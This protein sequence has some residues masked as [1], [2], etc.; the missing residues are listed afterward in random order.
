[1]ACGVPTIANKVPEHEFVA[2]SKSGILVNSPEE[3]VDE[4]QKL[5]KNFELLKIMSE[6]G[7][8]YVKKNQDGRIIAKK[9]LEIFQ[10]IT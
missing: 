10:D 4:I 9:F 2:E 1:M 3:A 6:N 5:L 7:I 8:K